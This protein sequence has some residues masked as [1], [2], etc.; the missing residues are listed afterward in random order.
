MR[1]AILQTLEQE[2]PADFEEP[3]LTAL[4]QDQRPQF[5]TPICAWVA[6]G[7]RGQVMCL[8]CR[9]KAG[10]Y[11]CIVGWREIDGHIEYW[12]KAKHGY[13]RA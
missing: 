7:E 5:L 9:N 4:N 10:C 13:P 3:N 6:A 8:D 2:M 12:R 1:L 11:G